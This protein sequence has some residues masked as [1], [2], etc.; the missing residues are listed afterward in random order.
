MENPIK[1]DDLGVTPIFGNTQMELKNPRI[2][3][4]TV[5]KKSCCF[6]SSQGDSIDLFGCLNLKTTNGGCTW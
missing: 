5:E 2:L 6:F 1:M 3:K 4:M